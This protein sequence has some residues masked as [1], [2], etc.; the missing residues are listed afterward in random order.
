VVAVS[1]GLVRPMPGGIRN[2]LPEPKPYVYRDTGTEM[3]PAEIAAHLRR[4][5]AERQPP[6]PA[7]TRDGAR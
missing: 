1:D 3:S 7:E 5:N 6:P 2:G 4:E